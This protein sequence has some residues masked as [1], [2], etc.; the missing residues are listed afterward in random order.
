MATK[1]MTRP[2][3]A[4][5]QAQP[6]WERDALRLPG[7]AEALEVYRRLADGDGVHRRPPRAAADR[8]AGQP[9]GGGW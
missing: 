4:K 6:E 8:P 1:T 9:P 2:A 7:L 3:A 5:R